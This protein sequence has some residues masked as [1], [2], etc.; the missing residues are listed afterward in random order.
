MARGNPN[1]AQYAKGRPKG[2]TN[3]TPI[4][5]EEIEKIIYELPKEERLK[6]LRAYRDF[7]SKH[8]PNHNYFMLHSTVAKRQE[9]A[10]GQGDL[11]D[12][13]EEVELIKKAEGIAAN[14]LK[15]VGE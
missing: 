15:G 14:R 5:M 13:A 8:N 10:V 6:R 11:Y 12:Y 2:S 4:L 1:I 7:Q 3:K 9:D